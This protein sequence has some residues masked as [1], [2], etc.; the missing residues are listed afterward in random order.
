MEP[1]LLLDTY[2]KQLQLTTFLRN[3]H[4]FAED[5]AGANLT[6]DRYLL[7][8]AEQEVNQRERN[9]QLRLMREARLPVNKE[10]A[11]FDFTLMPQFNKVRVLELAKGN[12]IRQ[13][14]PILMV[15]NPGLGKTHLAIALALLACRQGYKV[16]FFNVAG[17][18][19]ELIQAQD[20]HT[21]SKFIKT[22]S[23]FR[24]IV[25]DELGFIPFSATG[26]HLIFQFCSALY[27]KVA[28]IITTNLHFAEW[29]QV[30]GDERLTAALLDRLTHRAHILEFVGESHRF[31]QR[32]Q[33]TTAATPSLP[34]DISPR[35][36]GFITN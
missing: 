25:L 12:Y 35:Q 24:L 4:R 33:A 18:V 23:Q 21:L 31:R 32:L 36:G 15:G 13:A 7:A 5:A 1:N 11:D 19:N 26:A 22:A 27:E 2:L 28:L 8:L 29:T 6:Y 30:F 17:L 16:R 34:P 14:E 20:Q 10:L 9:R 3:Y